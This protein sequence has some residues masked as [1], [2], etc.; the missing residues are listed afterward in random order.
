MTAMR[1]FR[2]SRFMVFRHPRRHRA[3]VRGGRGGLRSNSGATAIEFAML[4]PVYLLLTCIAVVPIA[5]A[6]LQLAGH[7]VHDPDLFVLALPHA[8]GAQVSGTG[9][10]LTAPL[11]KAHASGAQVTDNLPTPGAPNRYARKSQ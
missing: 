5:T 6:G 2:L 3:E 11:T 8:A 10:T 1:W 4:F 7:A 9:I